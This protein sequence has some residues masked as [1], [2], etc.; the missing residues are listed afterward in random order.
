MLV[1]ILLE[2]VAYDLLV[3]M[4]F[5]G[6]RKHF[7][8]SGNIISVIIIIRLYGSTCLL[9]HVSGCV[10]VVSMIE[11]DASDVTGACEEGAVKMFA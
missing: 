10:L 2:V 8:L 3:A 1:I 9:V 5:G 7:C 11:F 4:S 6:R